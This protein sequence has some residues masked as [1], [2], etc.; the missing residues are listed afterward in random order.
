MTWG[1]E[2]TGSM[3][4]QWKRIEFR[5]STPSSGHNNPSNLHCFLFPQLPPPPT[6]SRVVRPPALGTSSNVLLRK[7]LSPTTTC[8]REVPPLRVK[9]WPCVFHLAARVGDKQNGVNLIWLRSWLQNI[10]DLF[11]WYINNEKIQSLDES[12]QNHVEFW[13]FSAAANGYQN[14]FE[15]TH[16]SFIA[17]KKHTQHALKKKWLRCLS[18]VNEIIHMPPPAKPSYSINNGQL[19]KCHTKTH[20]TQ[21][22][23]I[24]SFFHVYRCQSDPPKSR[25]ND[26][27][28]TKQATIFLGPNMT[29]ILHGLI[30]TKY[31]KMRY[32]FD[33]PPTQ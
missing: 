8:I 5:G 18:I 3:R 17:N 24:S 21:E 12:C 26:I 6:V 19:V 32:I 2:Q 33:L 23:H 29:R 7:P 27:L 25:N 13:C 20:F 4:S 14:T 10:C 16:D 11:I 28:P 1:M 30:P 15:N 9:E 22:R 31:H